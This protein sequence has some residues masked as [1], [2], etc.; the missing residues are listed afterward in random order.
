MVDLN[1]HVKN[2]QDYTAIIIYVRNW[3]EMDIRPEVCNREN[4]HIN[5]KGID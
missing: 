5:D 2:I 4:L 1:S 3:F